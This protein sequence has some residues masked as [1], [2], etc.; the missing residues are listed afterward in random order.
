MDTDHHW[1][2]ARLAAV[3]GTAVLMSCGTTPSLADV[4]AAAPREAA[5]AVAT[6]RAGACGAA[7]WR[8][9]ASRQQRAA[10]AALATSFRDNLEHDLEP[11]RVVACGAITTVAIVSTVV[12]AVVATPHAGASVAYHAAEPEAAL[13]SERLARLNNP[14]KTGEE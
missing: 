14:T 3:L 10:D 4:S 9:G 1:W 13:E 5:E 7:G 12:G 2:A 6:T 11:D 8:N